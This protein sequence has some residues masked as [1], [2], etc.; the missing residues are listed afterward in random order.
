TSGH[1][2]RAYHAVE[3]AARA[4]APRAPRKANQFF[5]RWDRTATHGAGQAVQGQPV[6]LTWSIVP[7]GTP[8]PAE[9]TI[10]DSSDPSNL[11]AR[12]AEVYG[13]DTGPPENQPWFPL[14]RDVFENIASRTGIAYLYEPIDDGAQLGTNSPGRLQVRG[15]I[16]LAGHSIDGDRGTVAYSFFPDKG[17]T[18]FDTEDS[19]F[20]NT[21]NDS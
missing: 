11:R 15:D 9:P 13:G 17:D 18:V 19:W 21:F 12:L 6:T 2:L 4:E 5:R 1:L 10:G 8:I 3:E 20:S 16:R 14:I 7:D